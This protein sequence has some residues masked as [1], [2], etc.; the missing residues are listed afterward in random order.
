[1]EALDKAVDAYAN[2][3]GRKLRGTTIF[4]TTVSRG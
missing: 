2:A 3:G 1:M 4:E